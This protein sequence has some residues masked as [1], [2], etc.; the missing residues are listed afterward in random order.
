[1]LTPEDFK[2]RSKHYRGKYIALS[3]IDMKECIV[4]LKAKYGEERVLKFLRC[5][6]VFEYAYKKGTEIEGRHI[7]LMAQVLWLL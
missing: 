3:D 7:G 1:M 5:V 6:Q 2:K 4:A